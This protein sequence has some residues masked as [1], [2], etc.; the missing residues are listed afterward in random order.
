MTDTGPLLAGVELGG[1]KCVCILGSGADDI[2]AQVRIPTGERE[3]TLAEIAAVLDGW[4]LAHGPLAALGI[5]SFGP[6]DLRPG[7]KTYGH[8]TLT[9]K[10]GWNATDIVGRLRRGGSMPVG[11]NTDVNGA[12]L[13]E[14]RWGA[15]RGL[16]DFA[17][18]TVGTGVGVG[19]VV[20]GRTV[21]GVN[22]SELGH[23]R[24]VR[25]P[26][27]DWP[28]VCAFHG[29]CVEGLASGP[30][31]AAR[32]GRTA[33]DIAVDDPVWDLAAHA[34]GQL[35]HTL[36]LATAPQRIL[37]GGGVIEAR[38]ELLMQVRRKLEQSLNG[39]LALEELAGRPDTFIVPPGLGAL[40]GP[41]G[42]LALA[43]DAHAAATPARTAMAPA[44]AAAT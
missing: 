5:A 41:L 34:L 25:V 14:R 7:S 21:F 29:A 35:L 4:Q 12:A 32:A 17:Y 1:T 44:R 6:L 37:I 16:S 3:E 31:I 40:A 26:G 20:G 24:I 36:V 13:A 2:R 28:G 18:V 19:L 8:I 30:A 33:T 42:A 39:Y 15:A 10:R 9:V 38:P 23:V 11:F 27:D 22:H 43:A